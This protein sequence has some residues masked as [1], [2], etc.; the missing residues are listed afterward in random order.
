[1]GKFLAA[2][3]DVKRFV[4]KAQLLAGKRGK[5]GGVVFCGTD[6]FIESVKSFRRREIDGSKAYEL[7]AAE[8]LD[9][10]GQFY[11]SVAVDRF[12]RCPVIIFSAE[13]GIDIEDIALSH[14]D[15]IKKVWVRNVNELPKDE[16][17]K[18]FAES[19]RGGDGAEKLVDDFL[20]IAER[21]FEL[22]LKKDCTLAE[23]NP[24]MLAKDGKLYAADAKIVIDD[25]ALFRHENYLPK[26]LRG[27]S[28]L[29][30]EAKKFDLAYVELKGNVA[31]IG[32]GAG[33]VMATLD[34][35]DSA[36][37]EPA[38]FCD[39]GGGATAEMMEKALETVL[40]KAG[41]KVIFV[42]IFGG[43]THCEIIAAALVDYIS[44]RRLKLPVVV[45]MTGT[46]E[47]EGRAILRKNGIKS[48][49]SFA[50][51]VENVSLHIK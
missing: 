26:A 45:R 42:N 4:L 39:V 15:K 51:A 36:G 35:L 17:L 3:P 32:N 30:K 1:L 27:Y 43:I 6:D 20:A 11:L 48:F 21:L 16:L 47:E 33:L 19:L 23:I 38:N 50:E 2:A 25:N 29:E 14:A 9:D 44:T 49:I 7:L 34:A 22:F 46:N 8:R 10:D 13:G 40:R 28:D 12:E 24:L 18:M 37:A 41:V 5:S 31:V